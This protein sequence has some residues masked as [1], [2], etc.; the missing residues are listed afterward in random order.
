MI[1][2][3]QTI[4]L[5]LAAG[6]FGALIPLPFA[7][8]AQDTQGIFL[9]GSYSIIDNLFLEIL[10]LAGIV[11]ALVCI[12]LFK[13]RKMQLRLGY[14][15]IVIGILLMVVAFLYFTNQAPAI[16]ESVIQEGLGLLMPIVA[17]VFVVLANYFIRK[18]EKL[19]KSMDRLR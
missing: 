11:L 15:L 1:Q 18:D 3:I 6:A 9:D 8:S 4:F 16:S 7:T 14:L 5:L 13:K 10:T 2:R 12:F 17:I 19:V